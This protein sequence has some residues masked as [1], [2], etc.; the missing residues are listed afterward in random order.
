M[1]L[2]KKLSRPALV[3]LVALVAGV[4][5]FTN[6]GGPR[7]WDRDEPRN[8]GC[9][10]EM[11]QRGDWVTP[12]FNDELRGHKPVLLY[13]LMMSAYGTFGVDEFSARFWS[14]LLAVGSACL[15][16]L[17]GFHLFGRA[18]GLLGGVMLA[19]SL[20]FGVAGRAATPDSLLIFTCTSALAWFVCRGMPASGQA[21]SFAGFPRRWSFAAVFYGILA[22]AV[23]AKGPVGMVLPTAVVG[24]FLLVTSEAPFG[25]RRGWWHRASAA[26]VLFCKTC[27]RMRLLTAIGMVL[28]IAAPWYVWVGLRTEG[29]FL[30]DFFIEHNLNRARRPMEGHDGPFFYYLLAVMLGFFPWSIFLLPTGWEAVRT[31]RTRA[32]ESLGVTFLLSWFVVWIGIFS[33]AQTKLPSY[34]TPCYP[35][36]ALLT[37]HFLVH[38][39]RQTTAVAAI[40]PKVA[41][42]ILAAVGVAM[43]IGLP[44]AASRLLPGDE[45]LAVIGAIPLLTAVG[46]AWLS[47]LERRWAAAGALGLG[48]LL[49]CVSLFGVAAQRVDRHQHFDQLLG[50]VSARASQPALASLGVLEPSWVFYARRPVRSLAADA[51]RATPQ[52]PTI[53][54]F[55]SSRDDAYVITTRSEYERQKAAL[56]AE[57]SVVDEV[58]YFLK[59]EQLVLLGRQS[60]RVAERPA[61]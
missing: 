50:T 32:R 49:L 19:T 20:M 59:E 43:L 52:F 11:L 7:L 24:A 38:W 3:A 10:W 51:A 34:I 42:G 41:F 26:V 27:W 28:A 22:L 44:I 9:A 40:W 15:T 37:A 47:R 8:A 48:A 30:Y 29:Q 4:V 1:S 57:I 36:L 31:V 58:P 23:L 45:W 13:W 33:I 5:M 35:A 56:P 25:T 55:L 17:M 18:V 53:E 39:C 2:E 21:T 46:A 54:Q 60:P 12:I 61:R 6:L 16:A 14:A